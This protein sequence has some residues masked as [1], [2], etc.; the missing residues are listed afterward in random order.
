MPFSEDDKTFITQQIDLSRRQLTE[1][2]EEKFNQLKMELSEAR[3]ENRSLRQKLAKSNLELDDLQQYGRRLNIRFEG[4]EFE[5]GETTAALFTKVKENLEKVNVNIVESD[6]VRLHRSSK[7]K[8]F[9][10]KRVAQTIVKFAT[11]KTRE[12]LHG[13]NRQAKSVNANFRVHSD[14]TPRRFQLMKD[15]RER[16]DREL[17]RMHGGKEDIKKLR[18]EEKVFA[19]TNINSDL[20]VRAKGEVLRFHTHEDLEEILSKTFSL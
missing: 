8:I 5:E 2:F 3:S 15:A 6:V 9:E 4:I 18:D 14:L 12:K 11:W 1:H 17:M 19:F 20:R 7:P 10:G 16:I 13:I